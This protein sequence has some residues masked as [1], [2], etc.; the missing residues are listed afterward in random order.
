[1]PISQ[2]YWSKHYMC[3]CVNHELMVLIST[4]FPFSNMLGPGVNGFMDEYRES[5]D[6][7]MLSS[8]QS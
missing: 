7:K 4:L 6:P 3:I 5:F 1:M 2:H 8:S